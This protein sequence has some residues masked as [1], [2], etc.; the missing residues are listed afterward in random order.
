MNLTFA[1]LA[2]DPELYFPL[3]LIAKATLLLAAAGVAT[4]VLWRASA[5]SRHLIWTLGLSGLLVLPL[6]SLVVPGWAVPL[7]PAAAESAALTARW[8][9][10]VIRGPLATLDPQPAAAPTPVPAT[11]ASLPAISWMTGLLAVWMLG[12]LL[13]L[14][15]LALGWWGVRRLARRAQPV[16]SAEWTGLLRDLSWILDVNVPVRLLQSDRATMPMTWGT[17]QPV[18]LLPADAD[19]WPDERRRVVLLHELAHVARRD[20][21]TQGFAGLAC[22]LYWFHPGVWY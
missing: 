6:L 3:V 7:F 1:S 4:I 10:P 13:V 21:L 9:D 14:V 11:Q 8:E 18:I 2:L 17:R 12:V 15:R 5:A 20:C 19:A 22:A 16:T